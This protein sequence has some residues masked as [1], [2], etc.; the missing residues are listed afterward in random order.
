MKYL[1][2]ALIGLLPWASMAQ[3]GDKRG[4]QQAPLPEHLVLPPS[5]PLSPEDALASFTLPPEFGIELVASEPL[6]GDPVAM[7]FDPDGRIWVVEM[8]GYMPNINGT[9][10]DKP[11]GRVVV[12]EDTDADGRMDKSTVFLDKLVMPRAIALIDGGVVVAEP[13]RLWFC[14]DT[15]GDLKCDERSEIA[16]DYATQNDPKHGARSNPEHASNGLMWA[17]DNWIYSANHDVQFRY[18]GGHWIRQA[19]YSRGQWGISQD[20]AGR[21]YFNSNSDQL[22]G[23]VVPA[24]Y[25]TRNPDF[26]NARGAGV[27]LASSQEVWPSRINPGVN[28]GYR[29][30]TLREDGRLRKYTGA[31]GPVIYRGN[32]FPASY[33]GNAFVCEPTG[34]MVRRNLIT[35]KHGSL[36]ATNAYHE[37]EFLTSSDERFRP[38]N[39]FNGPD[40]TL[41]IVDFYRGL[42][43]HRIYLTSFLRGQIEDRGLQEPIGL[44]RIYRVY[45]RGKDRQSAPTMSSMNSAELAAQLSHPN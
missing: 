37:M 14:K 32:Q 36:E 28:R 41:Y 39:A 24:A 20:N 30:G 1:S 43:Q 4:E 17:M 27:R 44:G 31:C 40:G 26:T 22:R 35:E 8:R 6:V 45:H 42:I 15:N 33:L 5:P 23:D 19:T 13:P 9:D 7:E 16:N 3:N 29:P 12:L 18:E 21:I 11:V 34:N 10:E 25:L 38:V 2:I